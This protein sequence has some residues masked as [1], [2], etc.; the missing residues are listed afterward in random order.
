VWGVTAG[1]VAALAWAGH[2][3]ED[4]LGYMG[5]ALW[6]PFATRRSRGVGLMHAGEPLPNLSVVWGSCVLMFWNLWRSGDHASSA[7]GLV[8]WLLAAGAPLLAAVVWRRFRAR[9]GN[10]GADEWGSEMT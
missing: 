2:V 8:L 10:P 6:F 3:L 1:V 5:S 9:R 4:Q 7:P